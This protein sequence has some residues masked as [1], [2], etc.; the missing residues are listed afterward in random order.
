MSAIVL[1][2]EYTLKPGQR[3]AY[4]ARAREHR[5]NVLSNEPGCKQ[6]DL[7]IPDDQPDKAFLYEIYAD[8]AAYEVHGKTKYM[9]EYRADIGPMTLDRRVT[10]GT[11]GN[12]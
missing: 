9:Q 8:A 12:G 2:V 10:R 4:V 11:P 3:D 1:I 6:F 5:D 7:I